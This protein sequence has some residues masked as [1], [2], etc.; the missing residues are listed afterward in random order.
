MVVYRDGSEETFSALYSAAWH[1]WTTRGT[2]E[3]YR[4][5]PAKLP[6]HRG[7]KVS[8]EELRH[9]LGANLPPR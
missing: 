9:E 4:F 3:V 5:D 6:S 1:W 2:C 7:A 8:E